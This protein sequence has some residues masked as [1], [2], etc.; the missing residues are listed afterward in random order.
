MLFHSP[1]LDFVFKYSITNMAQI[2]KGLA[3]IKS[4]PFFLK[5]GAFVSTFVRQTCAYNPLGHCTRLVLENNKQAG[6]EL[7]MCNMQF[8]H[9]SGKNNEDCT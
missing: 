7:T 1:I 8:A 9:Q 2:P 5:I 4:V 3:Y 6:F